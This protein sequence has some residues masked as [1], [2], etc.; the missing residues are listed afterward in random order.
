[1]HVW[2][3][4]KKIGASSI[5]IGNDEG[6]NKDDTKILLMIQRANLRRFD[7]YKKRLY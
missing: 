3:L 6:N 1:M 2:G 7:K 4:P 5:D